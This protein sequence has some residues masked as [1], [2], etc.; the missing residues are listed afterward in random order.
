MIRLLT[1]NEMKTI[2]E[3]A[4]ENG[5]TYAEM[6]ERAGSGI[7]AWVMGEYEPAAL[8]G[9][10]GSGNNGGDVLV[11]LE[12]LAS[13]GWTCRA[14]L[15]LPRASDDTLIQRAAAA[16]VEIHTC[17]PK[18]DFSTLD[19][20]MKDAVLILDGILGTGARL[21]LKPE[22]SAVLNYVSAHEQ[23]LDVIA[24]DCPS[25]VDCNT[26]E[27]APETLFANVTLCIEAVKT[28][29]LKLPAYEHAGM[30][31]VIPLDLPAALKSWPQPP[32]LVISDYMARELLPTR[33]DD[34]HKGSFGTALIAA[35]SINFTGAALLAARAACRI[36]T[37]LVRLAVP[38][39]LHLALAGHLPDV[40]WLILPHEMGV[41]SADAA[42]VLLKN[43]QKASVLLIGPGWGQEETTAEFLKRL[44]VS[45]QKSAPRRG[46]GF[47]I[48]D[49]ETP[50]AGQ[51]PLPALV[52]DADG[53]KLLG[54][55]PEWHRLLPAQ[56]ILTPH[57][58]EMAVLTGLPVEEIQKDRLGVAAR[59]AH[60]WQH[61]VVLKG[62]FTVIAHPDGQLA[63]LP[64]ATAALAHAGTGDVLAG[65]I[66]GLRAQGLS[67]FDA[68][69]AGAWVH[70]QAGLRV[71]E[72]FG[73][74]TCVLASDV[75]EAIPEII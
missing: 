48:V 16:G 4:N 11:A 37:G 63:V 18:E 58:G 44:L 41:I 57:P 74:T 15:P 73:G 34:A 40:T 26:G 36:G 64:V 5:V 29:L 52:I 12:H 47:V 24:V 69:V 55:I 70:G 19:D 13:R 65:I 3:E 10:V 14:L 53:L 28:G 67:A 60:E 21:P 54:R 32:R 30:F 7:A 8:I 31:V 35:G 23:S 39:P 66:T 45:G 43:L 59:F 72:R 71:A 6:M 22:I 46:I 38:G 42:E 51:S 56:A 75:L 33:P 2:E 25:G 17:Q 9:L 49:E 68:A 62:A 1:V 20:W 27:A 50:E 61:V